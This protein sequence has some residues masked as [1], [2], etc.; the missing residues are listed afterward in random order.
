LS[1]IPQDDIF[2]TS[3]LWCTDYGSSSTKKAFQGSLKRLGVDYLD[4]FM[5]HWPLCPS[6]CINRAK[7]LE[8]T[9]RELELL[10]DEGLC[11]AIG[12]SNYDIADLEKLLDTASVTPHVNQVEFH[13]FQN[14]TEL[15][16]YCQEHKIQME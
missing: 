4:L 1:G 6:S 13:P 16:N 5:L 2:L 3:K 12:V 9:W 8:E 14:P 15:Q 10:Y 11:R 7:T